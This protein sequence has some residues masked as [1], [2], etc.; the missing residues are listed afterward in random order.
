MFARTG[1]LQTSRPLNHFEPMTLN[2]F[3]SQQRLTRAPWAS[4]QRGHRPRTCNRFGHTFRRRVPRTLPRASIQPPSPV[5]PGARD[6]GA[7]IPTRQVLKN[8]VSLQHQFSLSNLPVWLNHAA[9]FMIAPSHGPLFNCRVSSINQLQLAFS[10]SHWNLVF[11]IA[12]GFNGERWAHAVAT[13]ANWLEAEA[14]ALTDLL[15]SI[16]PAIASCG[17][18]PFAACFANEID[19]LPR[20]GFD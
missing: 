9:P 1:R 13:L 20:K 18:T 7:K 3:R 10:R 19:S 12:I 11:A 8:R 6:E 14:C 17:G 16:R 5:C 4:S 15:E 2:P